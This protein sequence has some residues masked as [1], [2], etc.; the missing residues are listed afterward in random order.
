MITANMVKELREQTGAG[1]LDCKKA[2]TETNGN[3]EEAITW[4]REKGISKA[5]K[6]QSRI[7][8]EGLATCKIDGNKAVIIEV[9][10]ETD[11]VAK[12]PEF[13]SLVDNIANVVLNSDVKTIEEANELTIDGK[14]VEE[15]ITEKTATIGEKLSF[16]RFELVEKKDNEVFGTYSHMGGKIVT[17]AVLEGNN[18]DEIKE[19]TEAL[20]EKAMALSSSVYEEMAK[21]NAANQNNESNEGGAEEAEFVNKD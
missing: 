10:S 1:M 14:K 7:A 5:A 11:F 2:L 20:K 16:R 8:A 9:N 12:N 4:L 6:K 3:M 21:A 18:V 13:V 19:K 15:L 17:L